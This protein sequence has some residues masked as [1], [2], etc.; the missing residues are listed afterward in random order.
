MAGEDLLVLLRRRLER[1]PDVDAVR[2]FG[3]R[4]TGGQRPGS[5]LDLAVLFPKHR[6]AFEAALHRGR[7]ADELRDTLRL[8]VDV[9]DIERVSPVTF[10]LIFRD[11]PLLLD[12][13]PGRRLEACCRQLAI[14]HDMQPHYALQRD[15][16]RAFFA[17]PTSGGA[18]GGSRGD[19]GRTTTQAP[20]A[21]RAWRG[22]PGQ[23][24]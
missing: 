2:M 8:A 6:P 13:D 15:A 22:G 24:V 23:T 20:G 1:E 16:L 18:A 21:G 9:L 10:A 5:D 19:G 3:S 11:A 7:L 17:P 14:W 4:S 12:R